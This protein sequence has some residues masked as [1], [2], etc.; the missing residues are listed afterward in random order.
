ACG[1]SSPVQDEPLGELDDGLSRPSRVV[2]WQ[3]NTD[4]PEANGGFATPANT[5][6]QAGTYDAVPDLFALQEC[7]R[8]CACTDPKT[9]EQSTATCTAGAGTA[10]AIASR[11]L[12]Q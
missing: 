4:W 1:P 2:H 12:G 8:A 3:V 10:P 9:W 7:G 6:R 11:V 5:F